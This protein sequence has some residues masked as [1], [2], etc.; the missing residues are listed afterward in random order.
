MPQLR[1]R[2]ERLGV[3]CDGLLAASTTDAAAAVAVLE[4]ADAPELVIVDSVQTMSEYVE[5]ATAGAS[6][7]QVEKRFFTFADADQP[8][9]VES[10]RSLG[11]V[12]LAYEIYGT[13]DSQAQNAVL[14]L[15]ALTGDSH[16]GLRGPAV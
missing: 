4:S 15:H 6:V 8:L 7:G 9:I 1:A 3:L 2:A 11:P 16:G 14:V 5:Q 13:L 12:T 10:G